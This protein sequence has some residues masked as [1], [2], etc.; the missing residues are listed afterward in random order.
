MAENET[1]RLVRRTPLT[2]YDVLGYLVPGGMFL[3]AIAAFE[4]YIR[5]SSL[6]ANPSL[7]TPVFT[8]LDR[9]TNGAI[10]HLPKGAI[11]EAPWAIQA[12]ILLIAGAV[13][14]TIGHII[15]SFSALAIDRWYVVK[16]HG[17]P[18][19]FQLGLDSSSSATYSS[20]F[21][22]GFFFW[23]NFYFVLRF[24]TLPQGLP[25]SDFLPQAFQSWTPQA[26]STD[27]LYSVAQVVGWLLIIMIVA[28]TILNIDE[29]F[30]GPIRT[31]LRSGKLGTDVFVVLKGAL[32]GVALPGLAVTWWLSEYLHT[33]EPLDPLTARLFRRRLFKMLGVKRTTR[34]QEKLL[35]S[36]S[37]FWFAYMHVRA[38]S[39]AVSEPVENWLRLY[40]FA[41]NLAAALYLAFLYCLL[42]WLIQGSRVELTSVEA[43]YSILVLPLLY[44]VASFLVLLRY[45]YLFACYFTKYILR[46]FV[47]LTKPPGV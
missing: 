34:D 46:S 10:I 24:F 35:Y 9:L 42:W 25:L 43:H 41:R 40:G 13:A 20:K 32:I 18:F 3:A 29:Y 4:A 7:H 22:R 12:L 45:Y 16:A 36:S 21:H 2:P 38:S 37:T 6:H 8:A 1:S 15:A 33:R 14:Y 19:R 5:Q 31:A 39:V 30:G 47:Y 26:L 23:L 27:N 17:Y 44:F 11:I 28:K